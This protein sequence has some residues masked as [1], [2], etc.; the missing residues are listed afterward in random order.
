MPSNSHHVPL[1]DGGDRVQP[2]LTR[3][4][5]RALLTY[6]ETALEA[7]DSFDDMRV[8]LQEACEEL[9]ETLEVE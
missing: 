9:R 5:A 6:T 7:D 3:G 4:Q 2:D 8:Q 1:A